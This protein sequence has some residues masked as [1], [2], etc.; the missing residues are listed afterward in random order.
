M[1]R[2]KI[3]TW[4]MTNS[5]KAIVVQPSQTWLRAHICAEQTLDYWFITIDLFMLKVADQEHISSCTWLFQCYL[6]VLFTCHKI[7]PKLCFVMICLI[8]GFKRH[9][10][11]NMGFTF[12][13]PISIFKDSQSWF[14][15]YL[16]KPHVVL[17]DQI[18]IFL[19][20][21]CGPS[22]SAMICLAPVLQ[23][24]AG[25]LPVHC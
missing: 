20:Q 6:V 7:Q 14:Y 19:G 21:W 4:Y 1:I 10:V 18:A 12:N 22:W 16:L 9:K 17:P 24:S 15:T 13:D 8:F 2:L 3:N 5:L 25:S 23:L 11:E